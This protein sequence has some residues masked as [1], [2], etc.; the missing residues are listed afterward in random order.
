MDE[1]A[2]RPGN[3]GQ[4]DH[5]TK[6]AC[7]MCLGTLIEPSLE[8]RFG[9]TRRSPEPPPPA[10]G[11]PVAAD[12]GCQASVPAA[13]EPSGTAKQPAYHSARSGHAP[14]DMRAEKT[15]IRHA[16]VPEHSSPVRRR[17][18]VDKRYMIVKARSLLHSP[19]S[20]AA[21]SF[22]SQHCLPT[23]PGGTGEDRLKGYRR[24]VAIDLKE[25]QPVSLEALARSSTASPSSLL[26]RAAGIDR[27]WPE[28]PT[29]KRQPRAQLKAQ[30]G[31]RPKGARSFCG[32]WDS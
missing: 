18:R 31:R 11:P 17:N 16:T 9:P 20:F 2:C 30:L 14:A 1:V 4:H 27:R 7:Q 6:G 19:A 13:A 29:G 25:S 15:A 32:I 8:R 23:D 28:T 12:A 21:E 5:P 26:Q 22:S 24:K 3:G 10:L